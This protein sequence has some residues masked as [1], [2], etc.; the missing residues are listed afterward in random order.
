MSNITNGMRHLPTAGQINSIEQ[1]NKVLAAIMMDLYELKKHIKSESKQTANS[2][3]TA[4]Y[5][6]CLQKYKDDLYDLVAFI[7]LVSQLKSESYGHFYDQSGV[8]NIC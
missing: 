1:Y 7:E 5:S 2:K 4:E 6:T 8:K 3:D